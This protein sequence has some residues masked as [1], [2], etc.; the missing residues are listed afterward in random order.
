MS[1]WQ[2]VELGD[3]LT[4]QRGF[5]IVKRDMKEE[6]SY[7]VIFSSGLGGK[8]DEFKVKAPG[9]VIGRKRTLGSVF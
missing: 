6:G 3:F 8:H 7:D 9:V 4:F 2:E 1:E 5:N